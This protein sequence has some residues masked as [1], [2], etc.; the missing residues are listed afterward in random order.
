VIEAA[1]LAALTAAGLF[2]VCLGCVS[3]LAP[4]RA[5]RFLLG[6]AGSP[7]RHYLEL[8]ARFLVGGAF[9]L[10]APRLPAPGVFS[11]FGWVLLVTTT[12]LLLIPW[13]WHHC[14]ARRAVPLVLRFLPLLGVASV[15]LGV[16]VLWAVCWGRAA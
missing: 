16:L 7:A 10:A 11:V 14:F 4:S 2:F 8:T 13:H 15:G 6:F 3:W 1:A 9:V 5:G 12:G